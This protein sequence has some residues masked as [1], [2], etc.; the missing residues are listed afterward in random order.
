MTESGG[1]GLLEVLDEA[2]ADLEAAERR[3]ATGGEH[4]EWSIAGRVFASASR[5]RAEFRLAP[6][7]AAAALRTPD[8]LT[9]DRGRDWVAF[10]PPEVDRFAIDRAT[11]WLAS[12]W[13]RADGEA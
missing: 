3:P 5:D 13:R 4:V 12:A 8:T 11:A 10:T 9:S 1:R 2:A 6:E 7:V